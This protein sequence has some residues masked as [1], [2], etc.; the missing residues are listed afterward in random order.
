MKEKCFTANVLGNDNK[1][2]VVYFMVEKR[3]HAE[4]IVEQTNLI[5]DDAG[6]CE[7]VEVYDDNIN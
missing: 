6:V 2:Y 5:T 1:Y 3:E 4:N 7:M